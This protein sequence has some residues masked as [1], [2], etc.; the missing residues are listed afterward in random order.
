MISFLKKLFLK[1]KILTSISQERLD[2]MK[3]VVW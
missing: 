2:R 1:G 3:Q